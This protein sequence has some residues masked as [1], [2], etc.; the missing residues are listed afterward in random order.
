MVISSIELFPF[1]FFLFFFLY[2][3]NFLYD[4]CFASLLFLTFLLKRQYAWVLALNCKWSF[5]KVNLHAHIF[6]VYF[7]MPTIRCLS[8]MKSFSTYIE[9]RN[10]KFRCLLGNHSNILS[11]VK[12]GTK[13]MSAN[14]KRR[15][16][17]VWREC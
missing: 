17:A 9:E 12:W 6:Q 8:Q 10:N 13:S 15:H 16:L 4:F 14:L 11:R 3:F 2:I 7:S 5:V 1:S